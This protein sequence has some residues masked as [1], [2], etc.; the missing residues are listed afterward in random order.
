MIRRNRFKFPSWKKKLVKIKM[1]GKS[2]QR[3]LPTDKIMWASSFNSK[4]KFRLIFTFFLYCSFKNEVT[5]KISIHINDM[6][7]I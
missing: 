5:D 3:V 7:I 6:M 4:K 1:L 2:L